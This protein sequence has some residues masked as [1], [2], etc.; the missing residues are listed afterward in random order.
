MS[1]LDI[2]RGSS[3]PSR[4][5]ESPFI[6]LQREM[7]RM[8]DDFFRGSS[9]MRAEGFFGGSWPSVDVRENDEEVTVA[10]EL[11]GLTEKDFE[12]SLNADADA[13]VLKGEKKQ[14]KEEKKGNIYRSECSFGSFHR[15]IPLPARV[16]GDKVRADFKSG[17]LTVHLPK[18]PGETRRKRI[19]VKAT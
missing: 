15:S 9:P 11:P 16:D 8:F 3:L 14:E 13:L 17:L 7:N 6:A 4:H 5:E 12:V 18:R 1:L 2:R 10:A 19:E